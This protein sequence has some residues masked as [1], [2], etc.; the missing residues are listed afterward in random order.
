[1]GGPSIFAT[2]P[3][4][5]RRH[6]LR[7][8]RVRQQP[9][10]WDLTFET[11]WVPQAFINGMGP[12]SPRATSMLGPSLAVLMLMT[13]CGASGPGIARQEAVASA[14]VA[15]QKV[16]STPVILVRAAS[17]P[18]SAFK[19]GTPSPHRMVWAVTFDGTFGPPSCGPAG[20]PPHPCP[21]SV[22]TV[23]IFLDDASGAFLF[24]EYPAKTS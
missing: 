8:C 21:G 4:S 9:P 19:T 15:A 14:R 10:R 18:L 11:V 7:P 22:H 20:L 1:M 5:P 2:H 3:A 23:R 17:G 12:T 16:S 6:S 13:A 24:G